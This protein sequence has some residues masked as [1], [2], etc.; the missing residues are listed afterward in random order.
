MPF[1]IGVK[2][3]IEKDSRFSKPQLSRHKKQKYSISRGGNHLT[4]DGSLQNMACDCQVPPPSSHFVSI[5][6]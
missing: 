5:L 3:K 4:P 1:T 6:S 2:I